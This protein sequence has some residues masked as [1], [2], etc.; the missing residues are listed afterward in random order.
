MKFKRITI[1]PDVCDGQPCIRGIEFPV[2]RLLGLL[3]AGETRETIL[4]NHPYLEAADITQALRYLGHLA[5][6]A[7]VELGP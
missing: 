1:D 5:A 2:T 7:P 4:A 3:A 6:G